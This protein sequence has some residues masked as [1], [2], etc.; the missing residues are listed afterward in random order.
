MI[1]NI[2]LGELL[3]SLFVIY[4]MVMYFIIVFTVVFDVFRSDDLSGGKK[5]F[6]A[7]ALLIFP[8]VTMIA[9]LL[10]RGDGIGMRNLAAAERKKAAAD[11]YIRE[12]AGSGGGAA[13]ELEK[14]K[15]LLDNGAISADEYTALKARIL[16]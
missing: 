6:W 13:S 16:S 14:A 10:T 7:I 5:A 2:G 8:F 15:A 11:T 4:L 9:Y 3:W 12:V 1:A